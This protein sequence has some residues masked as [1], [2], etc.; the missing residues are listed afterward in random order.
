MADVAATVVSLIGTIK[1]CIDLWDIIVAGMSTTEDLNNMIIQIQTERIRFLLWCYTTG[2]SGLDIKS[3]D[4]SS[5]AP[6]PTVKHED[7]TSLIVP[8]LQE[9]FMLRHFTSVFNQ[10]HLA[11]TNAE[12]L[13]CK[14]NQ[15][16]RPHFLGLR[17]QGKQDD[18][19]TV[20]LVAGKTHDV[21]GDIAKLPKTSMW[22]KVKWVA[23]DKTTLKDLIDSLTRHN[24]GLQN[25]LGML[26]H[27]THATYARLLESALTS[28][29][30][31]EEITKQFDC[32]GQV[33]PLLESKRKNNLLALCQISERSKVL[34]PLGQI[35]EFQGSQAIA[36]IPIIVQSLLLTQEPGEVM[37][38]D[39][40][41]LDPPP[42]VVVNSL[43]RLRYVGKYKDE[44]VLV[45]W[46]YYSSRLS[47]EGLSILD[48]RVHMLAMQ[49][50]QSSTVPN[51]R[52]LH[53]LG[54][55]NA[56]KENRYGMVFRYPQGTTTASLRERLARD[57]KKNVQRDLDARLKL[58][59]DL[60]NSVYRFLSTGWLH[61]NLRADSVLFFE[62]DN[63]ENAYGLPEMYLGGFG[64]TRR[65]SPRE[66][67]ENLP[68][69]L[70]SLPQES[71]WLLYV[72]PTAV[73]SR[74]DS[75]DATRSSMY[76]DVYSFG[77][78]LLEIALWQPVAKLRSS[79][80]TIAEFHSIVFKKYEQQ[81]RST[82]GLK[83][84]EVVRRC[85]QCDFGISDEISATGQID[86]R[87]QSR[88]LLSAFEKLIISEL[89]SM[90]ASM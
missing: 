66:L 23:Q 2:F 86:E 41:Q 17:R 85:L 78:L 60:A 50:R 45:E 43:P 11:L 44:D 22:D 58:A 3:S 71:E 73:P 83:F 79:K 12:K 54:Y 9:A 34:T 70:N 13:I 29:L 33:P 90:F 63:A 65:D 4:E 59:R 87:M 24:D 40:S 55:L 84:T 28:T 15:T 48:S 82:V 35:E 52:V 46:R 38:L 14:Y 77:I 51:F 1:T 26:A 62:A 42:S 16:G 7:S 25:I 53:C 20:E 32:N 21:L 10:I 49:L 76:S 27:Q 57:Y 68:S 75:K 31:A 30:M 36:A 69:I 6:V 64:F 61:K 67:T 81:L 72:Q 88:M 39:P 5:L 8:V 37:Y 19:P 18:A 89:E 56:D 74:I 47:P 80:W